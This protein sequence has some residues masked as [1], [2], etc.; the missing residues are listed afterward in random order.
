MKL[1]SELSALETEL[2]KLDL[3]ISTFKVVCDGAEN[4]SSPEDIK[5]ALYYLRENFENS[6]Q[7]LRSAFDIAW[8]ID[9]STGNLTNERC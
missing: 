1:Y 2:I 8:D 9:R 3:I 4:S 7:A 5:N 6:Q